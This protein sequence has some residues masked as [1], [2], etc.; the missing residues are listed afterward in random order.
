MWVSCSFCASRTVLSLVFQDFMKITELLYA[1]TNIFALGYPNFYFIP[2]YLFYPTLFY[3]IQLYFIFFNALTVYQVH[4]AK[5][6]LTEKHMQ[7]RGSVDF[8]PPKKKERIKPECTV[9]ITL[10]VTG[11]LM[12][13]V[14]FAEE[15]LSLKCTHLCQITK[16]LIPKTKKKKKR[17]F[18]KT[19]RHLSWE[20]QQ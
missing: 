10:T 14:T 11:W 9:N 1:D 8:D 4:D 19:L 20:L 3:F 12:S 18:L 2:L 16:H 6:S 17:K 7:P 15:L 13:S 5:K